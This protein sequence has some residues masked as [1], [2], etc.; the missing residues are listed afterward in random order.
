M[1]VPGLEE[2]QPLNHLKG[3][4]ADNLRLKKDVRCAGNRAQGGQRPFRITGE[5]A[6]ARSRCAHHRHHAWRAR[7]P[8]R[9]WAAALSGRLDMTPRRFNVLLRELHRC[10]KMAQYGLAGLAGKLLLAEVPGFRGAPRIERGRGG[11][12][13]ARTIERRTCAWKHRR[14]LFCPHRS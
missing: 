4:G 14:R 1:L 6:M 5:S 11:F 12:C 8:A 13:H 2:V 10:E 3:P 7:W 9:S